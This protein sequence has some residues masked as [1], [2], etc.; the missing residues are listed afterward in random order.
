MRLL[1][2]LLFCI[3]QVFAIDV[4][5]IKKGHKAPE[6]GFFVNPPN[7]KKLRKI[8]EDKKILEKENLKLKDL[9]AIQDQQ[10]D[11]YREL[12]KESQKELRKEKTK[13][14][15]KGI[16]GFVL[17]VLATSLAAYAAIRVTR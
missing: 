13:G 15:F 7:M 14:N 2:V 3:T 5:P 9:S 8:N 16:G 6:D 10:I 12:S 1:I 17:G 4:Q 11:N